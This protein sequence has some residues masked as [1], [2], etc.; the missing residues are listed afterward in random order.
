MSSRADLRHP[1]ITSFTA[2]EVR[3]VKISAIVICLHAATIGM[4]GLAKAESCSCPPANA[5]STST[6][7]DAKW[8]A[9]WCG[10]QPLVDTL[11]YGLN[12]NETGDL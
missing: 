11:W 4:A 2:I 12:L 9:K 8:R 7:R 3:S 1:T 6:T 10:N 5:L